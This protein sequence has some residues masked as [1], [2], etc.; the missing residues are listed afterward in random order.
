MKI[1]LRGAVKFAA[2]LFV[3]GAIFLILALSYFFYYLSV[4]L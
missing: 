2:I 1:D 3:I 4:T